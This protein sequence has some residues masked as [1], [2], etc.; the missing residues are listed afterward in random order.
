MIADTFSADELD[1]IAERFKV[2]VFDTLTA[3]RTDDFPTKEGHHC[4]W[5]EYVALCPAKIHARFIEGEDSGLA[6]DKAAAA[7]LAAELADRYLQASAEAY[8]ADHEKETLRAEI[9]E[10]ARELGVSKLA[11]NTGEVSVRLRMVDEFPTKTADS[12]AFAELSSLV[13]EAGLDTLLT[14]DHRALKK[15]Y[16]QRRLPAEVMTRLEPFLLRKER[17]LV[18]IPRKKRDDDDDD[19]D[20][21]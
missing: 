15:F 18:T 8:A 21:T 20:D 7:T 12:N 10:A 13:R 6:D 1:E 17:S 4:R 5:C 14:L 9:I 11:G 16:D 3:E 19:G 2:K